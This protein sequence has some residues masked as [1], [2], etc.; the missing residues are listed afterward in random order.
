MEITKEQKEITKEQKEK[1]T[2]FFKNIIIDFIDFIDLFNFTKDEQDEIREHLQDIK[3]IINKSEI[4]NTLQ[5]IE[6][7]LSKEAIEKLKKL[8]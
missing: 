3:E 5:M 2:N 6:K 1:F 7:T 4:L 8:L